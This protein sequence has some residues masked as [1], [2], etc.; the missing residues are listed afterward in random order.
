VVNF[1]EERIGN[2]VKFTASSRQK[3]G[4]FYRVFVRVAIHAEEKERKLGKIYRLLASKS[5]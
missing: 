1:T 2:S 5:W 3:D 4:K